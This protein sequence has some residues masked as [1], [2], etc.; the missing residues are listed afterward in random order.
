MKLKD[1][2]RDFLISSYE[3]ISDIVFLLPRHKVPFNLIKKYFLK[4]MGAKIGKWVTFY[5]GIR[6]G[7]PDKLIIGDNVDLAWG[8]IITNKGGV[9]IGNR[10]LIG[11]RSQILSANHEIPSKRGRIFDAGH[12]PGKII[13]EDDVWIGANC[14]ITAGVVIGVGAVVA[15]GSVVT[16]NVEPY[17]IVAGIPAK[18]IKIRE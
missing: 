6:I 13:I 17:T 10:S 4:L 16:K 8:V 3:F 1:L 7:F 18:V 15:A 11:Y 9:E 2:Y 5:P 12:K 14:I